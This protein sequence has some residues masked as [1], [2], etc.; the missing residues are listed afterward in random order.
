MR[1]LWT[2]CFAVLLTVSSAWALG[3][4]DRNAASKANGDSEGHAPV[5]PRG[6]YRSYSYAPGLSAAAP[7]VSAPATESAQAA[8]V[9]PAP[10]RSY[11]YAPQRVNRAWQA[12]TPGY[13]RADH[14]VLDY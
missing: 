9:Q 6:V 13:L 4:L 5:R 2:S 10:T 11:S 3:P 14:K 8:P 1:R 7:A 12:P